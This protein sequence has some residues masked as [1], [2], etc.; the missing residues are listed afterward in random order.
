MEEKELKE[1]IKETIQEVLYEL[2]SEFL[3]RFEYSQYPRWLPS[4]EA[5][6]YSG[7]SEKTLRKLAREGEIYATSVGGG[8]LLFDRMSIDEFLLRQRKEI[9]V[10]AATIAKEILRT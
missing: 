7:L 3:P 4:K 8:K 10:K 9:S 5:S 6:R 1:I 2:L